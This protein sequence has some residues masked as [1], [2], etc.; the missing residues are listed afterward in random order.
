MIGRRV[1]LALAL[2]GSVPAPVLAA[3]AP[4][5]IRHNPF[6]RPAFDISEVREL[7]DAGSADVPAVIDLRITMVADGER[8]A[9]VGGNVLRPGDAVNGYTLTHV[10]EDRAVFRRADKS[11]TIYVKPDL[12][13]DDEDSDD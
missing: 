7:S 10:F 9:Y 12:A 13:G 1:I 3:D 8:L 5:G 4:P 6:A 11:I 2:G